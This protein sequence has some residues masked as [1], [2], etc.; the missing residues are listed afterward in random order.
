MF[1]SVWERMDIS[2]SQTW[3][4]LG[5][6]A[7]RLLQPSPICLLAAR[8]VLKKKDCRRSFFCY[9]C[10]RLLRGP[11]QCKAATLVWSSDT[12][13]S[14][15]R[16]RG[17]RTTRKKELHPLLFV[18]RCTA[19]TKSLTFG[20]CAAIRS[21]QILQCVRHY[22]LYQCGRGLFPNPVFL[23]ACEKKAQGRLVACVVTYFAW[24]KK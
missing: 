7:A 17:L 21:V 23:L 24:Q 10:R 4:L 1:F 3:L 18:F 9:T 2:E 20:I 8:C 15:R 6:R 11:T 5:K 13:D 22:L 14:C 12:Y 19:Q 16:L